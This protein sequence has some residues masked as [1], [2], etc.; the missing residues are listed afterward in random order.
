MKILVT[1]A[2]GFIA[3]HVSDA[4]IAAGHEVVVVDNLSTGYMHNVNSKARFYKVDICSEAL[5]EVFEKEK[6]DI[7]NHHA[8]QI[9]VPLSVKDPLNDAEINV[10]GLIRLLQNCV[11][12][13][14]KKVIYISSGGAMY[15][16]ATEYPTTE[17]YNPKP[18]SVYAINKMV[19]EN[20]L[21]FYN[22]QYGLNYTVLRYANVFGPRQVSHGEAGVVSIFIELLL[23][24]QTPN[25]YVYPAEPEGMIRD[26]VYVKDVVKANLIALSHGHNDAFN[27]GTQIETTTMQLYNEICTQLSSQI[28]PNIG[29]A[30]LG[31]LHRSLLCYDKAK[32]VLGWTPDYSLSKGIAETI[33]FFREKK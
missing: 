25:V 23:Q 11:K 32:G 24:N 20:Y 26:Y 10:K 31:D 19:G 1:G 16:E 22:H 28:R 6:P 8:A 15:G 7:V 30:R 4:Y 17:T 27:I 12:H 33:Q 13:S 21:A 18:L 5:D 2:A 3:S 9:S 14:V 29:E